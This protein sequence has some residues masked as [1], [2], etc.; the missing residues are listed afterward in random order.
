MV[1]QSPENQLFGYGV[2]D[3][4]AFGVENMG[5]SRDEVAERGEY[6]LELLNIEYLRR[7]SVSTLSA[8]QRQ[9]VCI[10]SVL[11]MQPKVLIMD[12]PVS[13]LDPRGKAMVQRVLAHSRRRA[14]PR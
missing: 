7:R 13:S 1:S 8:G 12:E 10:A 4:I 6:V 5:L 2:E 9:A 3:A 11:A 14:R